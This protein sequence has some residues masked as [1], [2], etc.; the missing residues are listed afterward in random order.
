MNWD[1]K[2]CIGKLFGSKAQKPLAPEVTQALQQLSNGTHRSYS[3]TELGGIAESLRDLKDATRHNL[4]IIHNL[5]NAELKK[6]EPAVKDLIAKMKTDLG[7]S[8]DA[9]ERAMVEL[10]GAANTLGIISA[11]TPAQPHDDDKTPY[12]LPVYD[13]HKDL[14]IG[15]TRQ[16]RDI[17]TVFNGLAKLVRETQPYATLPEP[18]RVRVAIENNSEKLPTQI[19]MLARLTMDAVGRRPQLVPVP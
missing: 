8:Y 5:M 13:A 7:A 9:A 6:D 15:M 3:H 14:V 18:D 10:N 4:I 19:R 11:K 2:A 16:L 1:L 12:H 17:Y